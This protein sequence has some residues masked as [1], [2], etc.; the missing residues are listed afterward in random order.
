MAIKKKLSFWRVVLAE[1][2]R[3]KRG[4]AIKVILLAAIIGLQTYFPA[5]LAF[6]SLPTKLLTIFV[7]YVGLSLGFS[8]VRLVV[9]KQYLSRNSLPAH[10][11]DNFTLAIKRLST[12][13]LH[14][15]F[16]FVLLW[17]LNIPITQFF[18][19]I[20]IFLA[21]IILMTRDYIVGFFNGLSLLF[22]DRF[23]VNDYIKIGEY[24]GR[25][26]DVRFQSIELL[27]DDGDVVYVPTSALLTKEVANFS[28]RDT[29]T[30]SSEF[31]LPVLTPTKLE[32][33]ESS[34]RKTVEDNFG[35]RLTKKG[36]HLQVS[37]VEKDTLV[38]RVEVH[39]TNYSYQHEQ[40]VRRLLAEELLKFRSKLK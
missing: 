10:H 27:T 35:N 12:V 9:I 18:T 15:V 17:L 24:K 33:L 19:S 25:I 37:K 14:F 4:L 3:S 36:V 34:L 29:K 40:E 26:R 28:K 20:S 38:I 22:T 8:L 21:A 23:S 30:I 13:T 7:Y 39:V 2:V 1:R 16:F 11:V 6:L 31:T 32:K 5:T